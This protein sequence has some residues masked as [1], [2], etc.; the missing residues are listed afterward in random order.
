MTSLLLGILTEYIVFT[1]NNNKGNTMLI[2]MFIAV[3][4]L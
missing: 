2:S 1:L 4:I 3:G